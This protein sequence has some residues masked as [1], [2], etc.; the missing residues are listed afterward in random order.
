[1]Y[2]T[3]PPID[4]QIGKNLTAIRK[5]RSITQVELAKKIGITQQTLSQY[6]RGKRHLTVEM[7]IKIAQALNTSPDKFIRLSA[8][9]ESKKAISLKITKRMNQIEKL[10][11]LNQKVLLKTI[12]NY[13]RG[14][15]GNS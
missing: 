12:D 15:K 5:Q 1:M 14:A 4:L 2:K 6:E 8:I 3:L 11:L 13:L 10:D 9:P 7:V